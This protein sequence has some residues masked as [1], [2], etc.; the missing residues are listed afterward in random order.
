VKNVVNLA[1]TRNQSRDASKRH[2]ELN[3]GG[4][5]AKAGGR[6]ERGVGGETR[7][8]GGRG[9]EGGGRQS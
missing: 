9:A 1:R 6:G 2:Q 3:G 5:G 8:E 4:G 7:A